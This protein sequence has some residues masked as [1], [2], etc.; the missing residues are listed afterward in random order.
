MISTEEKGSR[1]TVTTDLAIPVV[2]GVMS[3]KEFVKENFETRLEYNNDS[4]TI[5]V[6]DKLN[7]QVFCS[8]FSQKTIGDMNFSQPITDLVSMIIMANDA[9][10]TSTISN[11]N[12]NNSNSND[13]GGSYNSNLSLL[14]GYFAK[15]APLSRQGF[16][17][18]FVDKSQFSKKLAKGDALY[19]VVTLNQPFFKVL[20]ILIYVQLDFVLQVLMSIC[21]V[22][23]Y[24]LICLYGCEQ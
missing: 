2:D 9:S 24:N 5:T 20:Q 10:A 23:N 1:S 14:F 8:T 13:N 19:L 4:I 21:C 7:Q 16:N 6:K 3:M 18:Q 11:I 17:N 15:D 12:G 22:V